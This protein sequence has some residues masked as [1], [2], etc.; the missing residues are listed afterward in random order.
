MADQ[1]TQN[2]VNGSKRQPDRADK[3]SAQLRANLKRRKQQAKS[4]QRVASD[5]DLEQN[6][7]DQPKE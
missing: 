2:R 5:Q 4:R 7:T 3:L 1:S 6:S